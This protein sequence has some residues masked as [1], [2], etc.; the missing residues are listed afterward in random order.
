MHPYFNKTLTIA[1]D[2]VSKNRVVGAL[3]KVNHVPFSLPEAEA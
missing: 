1:L 3:T 2:N